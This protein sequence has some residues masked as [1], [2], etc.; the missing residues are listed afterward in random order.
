MKFRQKPVEVDAFIFTKDADA[1]A[2][3]WFID[4]VREEHILID[5]KLVVDHVEVYG[6]TIYGKMQR[7]H[8]RVGD[9]IIRKLEGGMTAMSRHEFERCYEPL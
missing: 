6:C 4:A 3:D 8:V 5:R 2:P 1:R 9:Y 7:I